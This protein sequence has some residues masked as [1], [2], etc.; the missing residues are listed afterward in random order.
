M[1]HPQFSPSNYESP[2]NLF[3]RG[4]EEPPVESRRGDIVYESDEVLGVICSR[5]IAGNEGHSL[6]IS[7]RQYASILDLPTA[8]GQEVFAV[9]QIVSRAMLQAF[10]CDGITILQNN[11]EASDQTVFHY[12]VHVIPRWKDDNFLALYANH[13]ETQRLMPALRRAE[14]AGVLRVELERKVL[15]NN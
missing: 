10:G 3:L 9:T 8:I 1:N 5:Q 15:D 13:I 11:G 7:K 12:H 14:L 6:V 2:F 4:I